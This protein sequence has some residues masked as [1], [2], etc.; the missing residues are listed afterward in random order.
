MPPLIDISKARLDRDADPTDR[1]CI[2]VGCDNEYVAKG[3]CSNH[4]VVFKRFDERF[5]RDHD[6][7][8]LENRFR[9]S[10]KRKGDQR[11]TKPR[12][13]QSFLAKLHER[14]PYLAGDPCAYCGGAANSIDHIE[15]FSMRTHGRRLAHLD[16]SGNHWMN[17]TAACQECNSRK[18]QKSLLGFLYSLHADYDIEQICR[19]IS[20]GRPETAP[21]IRRRRFASDDSRARARANLSEA[22]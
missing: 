3:L 22:A 15:P 6:A 13:D 9:W 5:K 21:G 1:K 11:A 17:L 7:W 16:E 12:Q 18:R 4:W 8:W 19:G 2:W 14:V 20:I 10:R